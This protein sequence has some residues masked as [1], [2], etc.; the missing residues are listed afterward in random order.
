M[1][2]QDDPNSAM[3]QIHLWQSY[4]GTF[5]PYASTHPH[6]IAGDF[7]KNVSNTFT[8]ASAQVA[9]SNKYV[10]K[11]IKPRTVPVDYKGRALVRCQW[12]SPSTDI[13][14]DHALI[15]SH[16]SGK[17]CGGWF[18]TSAAVLTHVLYAHLLI[19]TKIREPSN[20]ADA[21]S[22]ANPSSRPTSS[23]PSSTT[24]F[25]FATA[26]SVATRPHRC[27][28]ASCK[29]GDSSSAAA[30]P[31]SAAS[32]ALLAR[33]I[34]THLPDTTDA[35][36]WKKKHQPAGPLTGAPR[37]AVANHI[38]QRTLTDEMR[39]AAGVPLGC[40]LVL[41]N[42]ARAIPKLRIQSSTSETSNGGP[43]H[44]TANGALSSSAAPHVNGDDATGMATTNGHVPATTDDADAER[45]EQGPKALMKRV[46]GASK[47][48]LFYAM[49][50]NIVLKDYVGI[51]LRLIAQGGG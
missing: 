18:P 1:C 8:G 25:D 30:A 31:G 16:S 36:A 42:I 2:F 29:H 39:D 38:W 13:N 6:L 12:R 3:T 51:V 14:R 28:W 35:A 15:F 33:H 47:E 21:S 19:P 41:R 32:L 34:E 37:D 40:A 23:G 26:A 20:P 17:E 48:K 49:A 50:H 45:E 4:Q 11:G 7:I 10:I 44:G 5:L 27:E 9:G 46:F 24:G 22:E 43:V